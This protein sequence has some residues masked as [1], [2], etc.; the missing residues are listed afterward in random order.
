MPTIRPKKILAEC[1][2]GEVLV[3]ECSDE[4]QGNYCSPCEDA[5]LYWTREET[6]TRN[7]K[8]RKELGMEIK[9]EKCPNCG[10]NHNIRMGVYYHEIHYKENKTNDRLHL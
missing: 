9:N 10:G 4:C 3:R 8:M 1:D 2:C 6:V 5:P 7:L